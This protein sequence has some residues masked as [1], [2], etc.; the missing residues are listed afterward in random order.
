MANSV[1][2]DYFV[3]SDLDGT[4]K[5]WVF[6]LVFGQTS[7]YTAFLWHAIWVY[8]DSSLSKYLSKYGQTLKYELGD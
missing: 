3:A 2:P 4:K 1:D 5:I 7:K 8:T 6:A